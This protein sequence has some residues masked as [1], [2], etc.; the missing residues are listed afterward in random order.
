M[1]CISCHGNEERPLC[2]SSRKETVGGAYI[3]SP[4]PENTNLQDAFDKIN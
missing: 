3:G 2:I 4:S 1:A